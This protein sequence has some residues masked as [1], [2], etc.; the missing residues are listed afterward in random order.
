MMKLLL[1][2]EMLVR[3]EEVLYRCNNAI[4]VG[5]HQR[6]SSEDA[7]LSQSKCCD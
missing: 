7:V 3:K 1:G 2:A 6:G 5:G 4:G